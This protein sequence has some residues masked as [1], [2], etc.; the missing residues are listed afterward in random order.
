MKENNEKNIVTKK[1]IIEGLKKLGIEAGMGLMVHSSLSSFGHVEGGA[2]TV[3]QAL[4]EVLTPE[5]TLLMPSFNHADVFH[6][7]EAGFYDPTRTIT[8]NGKIPDTF[9]RMP[10][11]LRSLNPTHAFAAWGRNA[12]RYT[13]YHHRTLTMGPGSPLEL[14]YRDGGFC[15]MIGVYYESNTFHHV[16]EQCTGAPCLGPREW[17]FPVILP[18]GRQVYGR[19]WAWREA[20]CPLTDE[21][22]Y[23]DIMEERGLHK[24]T[25][26]GKS[27]LTLYRLK[28]CYEVV[29]EVLKNGKDGFPPCS[30]C[31]IKPEKVIKWSVPSDWDNEKQC[32]K[33]DSTSWSY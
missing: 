26:V 14:L 3:I 8:T 5:G 17:A 19:S 28:D 25:T 31:K 23:E 30:L 20:A 9:W 33:P 1:D 6:E 21:C 4:M 13:Q 2:E 32:L 18:D 27:I 11:V 12:R 15:L 29:E 7:G 22:R 10:G 24:Q 16:V